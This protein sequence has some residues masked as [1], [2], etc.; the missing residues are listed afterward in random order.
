MGLFD[1]F[2]KKEAGR[3]CSF[4]GKALLPSDPGHI[5]FNRLQCIDCYNKRSSPAKSQEQKCCVCLREFDRSNI[6]T[7][8]GKNYCSEC[9]NTAYVNINSSYPIVGNDT[10]YLELSKIPS[11]RM[12][13]D[14]IV[15]GN[16]WFV[17]MSGKGKNSII[18]QKR[19]REFEEEYQ[20]YQAL[21]DI[22][23]GGAPDDIA[24]SSRGF[25]KKDGKY[26]YENYAVDRLISNCICP[27]P[28]DLHIP[29]KIGDISI[30]FISKS[31]F[32]GEY[33][34]EKV[35]IHS[36]ITE[37]E[38][39]AFAECSNLSDVIIQN[40]SIIISKSAFAG[41]KYNKKQKQ[42]VNYPNNQ[43]TSITIPNDFEKNGD[44]KLIT[45]LARND[46]VSE[47]SVLGLYS[48]NQYPEKYILIAEGIRYPSRQ[49]VSPQGYL[50]FKSTYTFVSE[51]TIYSIAEEAKQLEFP[52]EFHLDKD[53][54][55]NCVKNSVTKG[56]RC[57]LEYLYYTPDMEYVAIVTGSG[58][59]SL[60]CGVVSAKNG[61]ASTYSLPKTSQS[62]EDLEKFIA[63]LSFR[64]CSTG[65]EIDKEYI[66]KKLID[67]YTKLGLYH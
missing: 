39:C 6:R 8:E 22:H 7:Y 4:C 61:G 40:E 48:N 27:I 17:F 19:A 44:Y 18:S 36:G 38:D 50:I 13:E 29:E 62:K 31:A 2:K 34:I 21:M 53:N 51:K 12:W 20:R 24:Y 41:T 1:F 23:R 9:F 60:E 11:F 37:I 45:W 3:K 64:I 14:R 25:L 57:V 16:H 67:F 54:V 10:A 33:A 49:I 5:A 15:F 59:Y 32:K 35:I 63:N 26:V 56:S 28:A 42:S 52:F 58:W 30:N 47:E 66:L 65:E 46:T 55:F 43:T